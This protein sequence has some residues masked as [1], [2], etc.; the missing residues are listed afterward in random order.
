MNTRKGLLIAGAGGL[1]REMAWLVERINAGLPAWAAWNLIGFLDDE[2][3]VGSNINGHPVVG[4]IEAVAD[5]PSAYVVCAVGSSK[6]RKNI[7]ERITFANH[8]AQFATLIDP[9]A[10][11]SDLVSVGEGSVICARSVV[12]VNVSV[13]KHVIVNPACTIGHDAILEN[14]A[15]LYS[16]VNISGAVVVGVGTEVGVGAQV[17]DEKTVGGHCIV[18]AGQ[19]S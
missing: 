19:L 6:T 16:A 17:I 9:S 2:K 10:E 13:G 4:R 12:T 15:T 11:I 1:G 7:V 18:G 3:P 14:Y 8:D 5:H